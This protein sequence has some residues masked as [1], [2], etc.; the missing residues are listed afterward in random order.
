[1]KCRLINLD[2][3]KSYEGTLTTPKLVMKQS[4]FVKLNETQEYKIVN[5]QRALISGGSIY[6]VDANGIKFKII[7]QS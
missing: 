1:M 7:L 4:V 3:H 6:L 2:T 5:I